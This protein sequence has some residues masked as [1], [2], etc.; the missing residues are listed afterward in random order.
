MGINDELRRMAW[1][2][3]FPSGSDPFED[4]NKV[5]RRLEETAREL[6]VQLSRIERLQVQNEVAADKLLSF[7]DD[8]K[9]HPFH[10]EL[11]NDRKIDNG[12]H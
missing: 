1:E 5:T 7:L 11:D 2:F 4:I 10:E 3:I 9:K 12:H 8:A 6:K